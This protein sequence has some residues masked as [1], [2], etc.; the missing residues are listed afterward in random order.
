MQANEI[1]LTTKERLGR[2]LKALA[3]EITA[4]DKQ[5]FMAEYD[6]RKSTV[7]DYIRGYVYNIDV[8]MK[9]L[10]FFRARIAERERLIEN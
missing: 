7:S 5:R 10:L 4:E 3:E 9:M 8:A 6:Y 2:E 1:K